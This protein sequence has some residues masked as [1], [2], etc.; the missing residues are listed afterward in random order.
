MVSRVSRHGVQPRIG[1]SDDDDLPSRIDRPMP[2][3]RDQ[4]PAAG[5]SDLED[6]VEVV[7]ER[8]VVKATA[9]R[10]V[11]YALTLCRVDG[12]ELPRWFDAERVRR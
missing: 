1:A 8:G 10:T 9:L 3:A 7:S 4:L 5:S 11:H 2:T 6:R 12:E